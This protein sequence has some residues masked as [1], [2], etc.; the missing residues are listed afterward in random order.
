MFQGEA[1]QLVRIDEHLL[2]LKFDRQKSAVNVLD[3][4]AMNEWREVNALL[5]AQTGVR[6]LLVTSG[7]D[8]FIVG[9]DIHE[10]T[11]IF[12]L[13]DEALIK[14]TLESNAILNDFEDLPFPTVAAINGY[15]LGGGFEV[16][17]SADARVI[18][19]AARV[20]FPEIGLGIYPAYG[21]TVRLTRL[22][23]LAKAMEWILGAQMHTAQ[24][25]LEIGAVHAAVG[26][27]QLRANGLDLLRR[28]NTGEVDWRAMRERKL[29]PAVATPAEMESAVAQFTPM[30][31]DAAERQH[32]PAAQVALGMIRSACGYARAQAQAIETAFFPEV[33][34]SPA[35][36]ALIQI[37]LN[38]QAVKKINKGALTAQ[39]APK[40]VA[41]IGAGIMGGGIAY[42]SAF[43]GVPVRLKDLAQKALDIGVAEAKRQL[44][45]Q[46]KSGRITLERSEAVI[47]S[48]QPQ[49]D[50][51]GFETVDLAVEAVVEDMGVKSRVLAELE[52]LLPAHAVMAT[53]TSSL[54]VSDLAKCLQQPQRFVGLHFFNPVPAMPLVEVIRGAQTGEETVARARA[55]VQ[56][57]GKTPVV[58]QDCPGFLVN[59]VVTPYLRAFIRMVSLGADPYAIDKAMLA[60]GWPMGPA[61]LE[62]VVGLD[63]GTRVLDVIAA[64]YGDRMPVIERNVLEIMVERGLLGQKAGEGFYVY[65]T[66]SEGKSTRQPNPTMAAVLQEIQ[67]MGARYFSAEEIVDCL[68]I[69]LLLESVHCMQEKIVS[70]PAELDTALLFGL[71]YPRYLG[72]AL[73][74]IDQ[75]GMGEL[76]RRSERYADMGPEYQPTAAMRE[77]ALQDG[78]FY[79]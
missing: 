19:E 47:S 64:G 73:K 5:K 54:R 45:R 52:Q 4:V 72:G 41:V 55:F 57:M 56:K 59:R 42:S 48:I 37:Y 44:A 17:L 18:S 33:A 7:K 78:R 68:M 29:Q 35:A 22:V 77:M 1:I 58:V 61:H 13:S 66:N 62:D 51:A 8:V 16:A 31:R 49:L 23:P 63:T 75:M 20:G 46:V 74:Q 24:E 65:S 11:G 27:D 25:A 70:S 6:G 38:D 12:S 10:F 15:A 34:K 53:N 14:K 67:P 36:N 26:P 76:I 28:M 43:R 32:L 39:L 30:A 3:S 21:G 79:G 9:A 50:F 2:E 40:Q 69:P 60:Y 71:G